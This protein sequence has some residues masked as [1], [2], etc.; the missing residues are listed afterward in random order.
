MPSV[1]RL[2]VSV[3]ANSAAFSRGMVGA[4]NSVKRF[5]ANAKRTSG[6]T[7]ALNAS[8][9]RLGKIAAGVAGLR[10]LGNLVRKQE[11][12]QRSLLQSQ[13]I[14]GD[15]SETMRADMKNAA[16]ELARTTVASGEDAAK[17]FFFLASAGLDAKTS[18]E[19]LPIVGK[20]AQAGMFDLAL[21]T[22]LV[23]DAQSALG[24]SVKDTDQTLRNM[25]RVADVLVR[26]NTLA[27]A[28][29]RQFSEALTNKAGAALKVLGKDIEEGIGAL[30]AFADQGIKGAEAGTALNIVLRDLST[31]GIQNAKAFREAGIQIFDTA[32]EMRNLGA[33]IKDV[34]DALAGAS[35][36]QAKWTL[37]NLGFA[38][39]SVI[40]IQTLLGMSD[41][42]RRVEEAA[43]AAGGAMEEVSGKMLTPLQKALAELDA[44]VLKF[45]ESTGPALMF[46]AKHV[47]PLATGAMK[48]LG[49]VLSRRPI[50]DAVID[51][52]VPITA[53]E[54]LNAGL[55]V[56]WERIV[57]LQKGA[58][59]LGN[60]IMAGLGPLQFPIGLKIRAEDAIP[61]DVLIKFRARV[62]AA[63]AALKDLG[64]TTA[65]IDLRNF[66]RDFAEV[67][68]VL[69]AEFAEGVKAIK[70]WGVALDRTNRLMLIAES[71]FEGTR[72][73]MERFTRQ[74][75]ELREVFAGGFLGL[76]TMIR[77]LD[78][79]NEELD[80]ATK[81]RPARFTEFKQIRLSRV[82]IGGP[83]AASTKQPQTIKGPQLKEIVEEL[84]RQT[85]ILDRPQ[86]AIAG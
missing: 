55:R 9:L 76:E 84:R 75:Q 66:K 45:T 13:A 40:F 68:K 4:S 7:K 21:A 54:H 8:M 32:N 28:S 82:A 57:Q 59:E 41:K 34:E 3:V 12:F 47:V 18:L 23:T 26:A 33:I 50:S 63:E 48:D 38:D 46:F 71:I 31:K 35:D 22:D 14:M 56:A 11:Q 1:A 60:A 62:E 16:I 74:A 24:L 19:A 10:A 29:V 15:L 61:V 17:A 36:A 37:L 43:Y 77:Q 27:N 78:R 58:V 70:E 2:S 53:I 6:M 39:K 80:L 81:V 20:F 44:S 64:L 5:G 79:L 65:Q 83:R 85:Q 73:P 25:T 52:R 67:A 49:I 30:A 72:T 69:P 86:V 42:M 51:V